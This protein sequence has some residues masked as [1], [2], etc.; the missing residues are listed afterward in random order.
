MANIAKV[1]RTEF[2]QLKTISIILLAA[3]YENKNV[4]MA[5]KKT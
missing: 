5:K 3:T 4:L 1:K 2:L